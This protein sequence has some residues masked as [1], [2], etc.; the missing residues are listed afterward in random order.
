[1]ALN[2]NVEFML[3]PT[4]AMEAIFDVVPSWVLF[5]TYRTCMT[6]IVFIIGPIISLIYITAAKFVLYLKYNL[7]SHDRVLQPNDKKK[8]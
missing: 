3:C 7:S 5:P 1:M 4:G 6:I 2:V 8:I